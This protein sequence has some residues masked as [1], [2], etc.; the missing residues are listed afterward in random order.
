[1]HSSRNDVASKTGVGSSVLGD[2]REAAE[3]SRNRMNA[4]VITVLRDRGGGAAGGS[5]GPTE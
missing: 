3:S 4:E 2:R 1:M 5:K